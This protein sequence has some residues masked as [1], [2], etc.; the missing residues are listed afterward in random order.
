MTTYSYDEDCYS[1]LHK[2]AYGFRPRLSQWQAWE[3]MTPDEKEEEWNFLISVMQRRQEEERAR[4]V[5]CVAEF[6]ARVETVIASG[7][8]DRKTA[9]RWLF[10][11]EQDEYL[12]FDPDYY[13]YTYGLP[14][15][16]FKGAFA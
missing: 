9:I 16:Y 3:A 4:Q 5:R 6:E 11:A 10:D 7:A 8:N 15:G 12:K 14:Y 2:D 13:C 1:D